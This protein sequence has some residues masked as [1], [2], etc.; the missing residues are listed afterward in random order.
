MG[1]LPS[2]IMFDDVESGDT[3]MPAGQPGSVVGAVSKSP[4][5]GFVNV[6]VD[7]TRNVLSGSV[8]VISASAT[9]ATPFSTVTILL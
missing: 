9:G 7:W 1:A 2:R 3:V 8:I 5:S 4:A 6:T